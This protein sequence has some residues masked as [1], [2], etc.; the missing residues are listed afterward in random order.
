MAIEKVVANRS[1]REFADLFVT[2]REWQQLRLKRGMRGLIQP[3]I[4]PGALAE[5]FARRSVKAGRV[6]SLKKADNYVHSVVGGIKDR[7]GLVVRH[8]GIHIFAT[9]SDSQLLL[10]FAPSTEVYRTGFYLQ[11][12]VGL[13]FFFVPGIILLIMY[14]LLGQQQTQ[15]ITSSIMPAVLDALGVDHA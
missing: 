7:G 8:S 4:P 9:S 12:F 13:L 6:Y 15:R 3:L 5:S 1:V 10:R 11:I 14:L 2:E